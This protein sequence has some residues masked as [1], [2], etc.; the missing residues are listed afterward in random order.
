MHRSKKQPL[1]DH[2]VGEC[3]QPVRNIEAGSHQTDAA[4]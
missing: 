4:Q 3:E 1:F 2:L